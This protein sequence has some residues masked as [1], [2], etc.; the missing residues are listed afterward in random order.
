MNCF[1]RMLDTVKLHLRL[2]KMFNYKYMVPINIKVVGN[3]DNIIFDRS[4]QP[5]L[6]TYK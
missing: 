3:I 5:F 4:H 2:F 6:I 1:H